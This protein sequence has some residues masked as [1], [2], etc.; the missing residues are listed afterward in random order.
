MNITHDLRQYLMNDI[1]NWILSH[2]DVKIWMGIKLV[3]ISTINIYNLDFK[4]LSVGFSYDKGF[5]NKSAEFYFDNNKIKKI[6]FWPRNYDRHQIKIKKDK[7]Y[8]EGVLNDVN[9]IDKYNYICHRD[10]ITGIAEFVSLLVS[11]CFCPYCKINESRNEITKILSKFDMIKHIFDK[12]KVES[13]IVIE[14]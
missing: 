8:I 4:G 5:C 12:P 9:T 7:L 6:F 13:D 1:N 14:I 10:D 2:K 3:E 11:K